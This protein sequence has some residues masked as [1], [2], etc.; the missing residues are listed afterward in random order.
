MASSSKH[1]AE[2]KK[3]RHKPVHSLRWHLDETLGKANPTDT[4][5]KQDQRSCFGDRHGHLLIDEV[6]TWVTTCVKIQSVYLKWVPTICGSGGHVLLK[7]L[8]VYVKE[9]GFLA[10]VCCKKTYPTP[11]NK[12][13]EDFT[14]FWSYWSTN[15]PTQ[16]LFT[17]HFILLDI[18][19]SLGPET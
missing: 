9:L 4:D 17:C 16:G 3:A 13:N 5:R 12:S 18:Y 2:R 10:H 1:Y 8:Y 19:Y 11:V 7:L 14:S 15:K 6:I